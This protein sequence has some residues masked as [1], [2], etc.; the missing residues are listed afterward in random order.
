MKTFSLLPIVLTALFSFGAFAQA[1]ISTHEQRAATL[2]AMEKAINH[3]GELEAFDRTALVDFFYPDFLL[4]LGPADIELLRE[5]S[6]QIRVTGVLSLGGRPPILSVAGRG[7]VRIGQ[8]M[9]FTR[10]GRNYEVILSNVTSNSYT[11]TLNQ[12]SHT[13]NF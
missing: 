1:Q 6:R 9:T 10:E 8:T 12:T 5:F 13:V 7:N 11:L 4:D 2:L 3:P